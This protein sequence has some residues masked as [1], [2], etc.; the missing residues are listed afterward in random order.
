MKSNLKLFTYLTFTFVLFTIIGTLSHEFGHYLVGRLLGYDV[1]INYGF[2]RFAPDQHIKP[3]LSNSYHYFLFILGGPLETMLTGTIGMAL[4]YRYR[5]SFQ[6]VSHLSIQ[7]W[8]FI[9]IALFWLRQ[10]FNFITGIIVF[11]VKGKILKG[12]DES[13]LDR[14]LGFPN[15]TVIT[16]T[17]ITAVII[18]SLI[19]FQF[20]PKRQRLTFIVSGLIG[21]IAGYILWFHYLGKI[22]LP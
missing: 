7:Q 9:F 13:K 12:N 17:G 16:L 1:Y 3:S 18:V 11:I 19:V 5:K 22:I 20:I 14:Y 2:T 21:G 8:S 4:I 10:I 15:G 6:S